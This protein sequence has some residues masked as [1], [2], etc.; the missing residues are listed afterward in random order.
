MLLLPNFGNRLPRL[1]GEGKDVG[2]RYDVGDKTTR[3]TCGEHGALVIKCL[4]E[5]DPEPDPGAP[6][7]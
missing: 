4:K 7:R 2:A 3:P 1:R 5:S 6:A